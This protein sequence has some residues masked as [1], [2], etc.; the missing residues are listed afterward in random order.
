M[1]MNG[2]ADDTRLFV[3]LENEYAQWWEMA[4]VLIEVGSTGTQQEDEEPE[5][6]RLRRITLAAN[7]ARAAGEALRS[8]SGSSSAARSV[9]QN[10]QHEDGDVFTMINGPPRRRF[11]S[12][13]RHDLS[14]RQ[15]EVLR[16][17]LQTPVEASESVVPTVDHR[18][19]ETIWGM[20]VSRRA[21][22]QSMP[23]LPTSHHT[24]PRH[25]AAALLDNVNGQKRPT[26]FVDP[27]PAAS[28]HDQAAA[29]VG[30]PKPRSRSGLAGLRDFLRGLKG[31]NKAPQTQAPA[32]PAT[33]RT[34]RRRPPPLNIAA[35]DAYQHQ[36]PPTSP[37]I[38]TGT[39]ESFGTRTG[40][41]RSSMRMSNGSPSKNDKRRRPSLRGIFRGGSGN[42]SELVKSPT[43]GA[44]LTPVQEPPSSHTSSQTGL[45]RPPSIPAL[46]RLKTQKAG[47]Y[48]QLGVESPP[49]SPVRTSSDPRVPRTPPPNGSVAS[50]D[51]ATLRLRS[52]V[53]GLGHPSEASPGRT[54]SSPVNRPTT[55]GLAPSE[56]TP[57]SRS[58][59]GPGRDETVI[60]LTPEN[61]PV[62]LDYVRQCERKLEEWKSRAH[63]LEDLKP[64]PPP[65]RPGSINSVR[66]VSVKAPSAKSASTVKPS[67]ARHASS[68]APSI[69]GARSPS[70][71]PLRSPPLG[72]TARMPSSKETQARTQKLWA[73]A[74]APPPKK[75]DWGVV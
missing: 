68:K 14:K 5:S 6:V 54:A 71:P 34:T 58:D 51:D 25:N 64:L 10:Y 30:R 69:T 41:G 16:T 2:T 37:T 65:N 53:L 20:S 62:L 18:Q 57:R 15:L 74:Q 56:E 50:V 23:P 31:G 39:S 8:L 70:L 66:P 52:R 61:L 36:S 75:P 42:W 27:S 26:A 38:G 29:T 55:N 17:M 21:A 4:T 49:A 9:L 1:L 12:A 40:T 46:S 63:G 28:A 73:Q 67:T 45:S 47:E 43:S 48:G 60:A 13:G 22:H 11:G 7:D 24:Q 32:E 44:P 33:L 19:A 3:D 59:T 72:A 35:A